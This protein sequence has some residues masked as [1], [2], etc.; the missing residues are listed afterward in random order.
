MPGEGSASAG[1]RPPA[2]RYCL[3]G[4]LGEAVAALGHG[5]PDVLL[6][7]GGTD[8]MAR[9]RD[10]VRGASVVDVSRLPE[11][12]GI[13]RDGADLVVGAGVT[14]EE[15]RVDP[16]VAADAPILAEVAARFASPQIRAVATLGGNVANASPAGDGVAALWALEA[17]VEALTPEGPAVRGLEEVVAG[18]GR[19]ALPRGSLL[20]GFRVAA[21]APREGQA[22]YKLVNRAWPE[23]PM[24]IA[25]ASVAARVRLDDGGQVTLARIVLGAVG[26]TPLRVPEGEAGLLGRRPAAW[27]LRAIGRAARAAARP[28]SDLRATAAYRAA[29]LP[30]LVAAALARAAAHAGAPLPDGRSAAW[31]TT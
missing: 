9:A 10:R 18:P 6:L 5:P 23:H 26:P 24:A 2:A 19:L 4:S 3:A 30:A 15:C 20:V 28:I 14:W 1:S 31:A 21:R 22:F 25:V 12:R 11:L 7:A 29:V 17:R 13:A 27:D 16:Q 8:V